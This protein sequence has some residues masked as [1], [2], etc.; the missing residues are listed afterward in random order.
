[1]LNAQDLALQGYIIAPEYLEGL[2][3][4]SGEEQFLRRL[5]T[6]AYRPGEQVRLRQDLISNC[7]DQFASKP[8][9]AEYVSVLRAL[10]NV[11]EARLTIESVYV[12]PKGDV[13]YVF[14]GSDLKVDASFCTNPLP[15]IHEFGILTL[16]EER[17]WFAHIDENTAEVKRVFEI[18]QEPGRTVQHQLGFSGMKGLTDLLRGE[19]RQSMAGE[20]AVEDRG[21]ETWG[22]LYSP[23]SSSAS[24][25]E[26][27]SVV[28]AIREA[29]RAAP[30]FN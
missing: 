27:E 10:T 19:D 21:A 18:T 2:G 14:I 3:V 23:W 30:A 7:I 5:E 17:V 29:V 28:L 1:M 15:F 20:F 24:E 16:Q 8:K 4:D 22:L 25:Q 11:G 9:M 13:N 6:L 26:L 12:D